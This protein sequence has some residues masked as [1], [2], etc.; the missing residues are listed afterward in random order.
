MSLSG[1][2]VLKQRTMVPPKTRA[3]SLVP[4]GAPLIGRVGRTHGDVHLR[5]PN[6]LTICLPDAEKAETRLCDLGQ[7]IDFLVETGGIEPP[8]F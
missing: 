7:A 1:E 3:E 8:T 6:L 4:P 2:R 5:C